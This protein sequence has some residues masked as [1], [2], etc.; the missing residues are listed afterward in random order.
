ME[1]KKESKYIHGHE[2]FLSLCFTHTSMDAPL[3]PAHH[4]VLT[5]LKFIPARVYWKKNVNSMR[6]EGEEER[7]IRG[8]GETNDEKLSGEV[9]KTGQREEDND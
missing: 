6:T 8:K 7:D 5:L 4:L 9:E 3:S 1:G 2:W